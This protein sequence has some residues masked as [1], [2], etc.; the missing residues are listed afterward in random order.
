MG[1]I[2]NR[3]TMN[4]LSYI[5][6]VIRDE[7]KAIKEEVKESK[8]LAIAFLLAIVSLIVYLK[9]FPDRHI[10]FLTGYP[11]S[12]WSIFA[13][14]ASSTLKKNDIEF[15][16]INTAGAVENARRLDDSNDRANAG[17]TYGLAL[18]EAELDGI[19]SLGSVGYEPVWILYNKNKVR[20]AKS[21]ADFLKYRV[22]LGPIESGSYRIAKKIF[23]I[24]GTKVD[25]NS[26]FLPDSIPNNQE[27]LKRGELDALVIVSSNLDPITQELLKSPNIG[28]FDFKNASAFSKQINSFVTLTLPADSI[29]I[30]NHIPPKDVTLLAT[31]TSLVVKRSMH[32]DLQL[33]ILMSTKDANRSSPNLFFAKRDEFPAY[34]DPLIPIS[35]VAE[36]FYD[37]GPPHAMQYLPYWLAGFI[38]RAWLLLLTILAVFY[39]LSKLNI[40]FRKFR[41]SLKE[42]PHYRELLEM[43]R[44]IQRAPL[45][46]KEKEAMLVRLDEINAHALHG[47]V[48]I[49]EEAAYFNFLNAIFLLRFKILNLNISN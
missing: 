13:E 47:G 42:I 3:I 2:L 44:R 40:H 4:T 21:L 31:T 27:K 9:P 6:N 23:Q 29:D 18:D 35:P 12:D 19:Y 33:A 37:Y 16:V 11:N 5:K 49:S 8:L 32:P 15:L 38:D 43:E 36:R 46:E 1:Q 28:I 7:I 48:P 25:G 20:D 24:T 22:G 41:F 34:R 10:Y 14:S 39:P 17:F 26:L 45:N 30:K